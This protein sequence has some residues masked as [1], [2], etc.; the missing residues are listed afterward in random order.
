MGHYL[1]RVVGCVDFG[2]GVWSLYL[3]V[4]GGTGKQVLNFNT[5]GDR[6]V[7]RGGGHVRG[8]SHATVRL[9]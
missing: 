5:V 3:V 7:T 6:L 8:A 2:A 9:A 4:Q 1:V